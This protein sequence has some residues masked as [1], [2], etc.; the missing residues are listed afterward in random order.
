M[1]KVQPKSVDV[2]T[3]KCIGVTS[4]PA[5]QAALK[6]VLEEVKAEILSSV[7]VDTGSRFRNRQIFVEAHSRTFLKEILRNT[8]LRRK[9]AINNS[10]VQMRWEIK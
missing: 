10:F 7:S 1:E 3:F 5:A 6:S 2:V 8:V 9:T 4:D